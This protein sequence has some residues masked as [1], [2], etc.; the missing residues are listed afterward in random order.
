MPYPEMMLTKNVR[1]MTLVELYSLPLGGHAFA[2]TRPKRN[3][4]DLGVA[5]T[6]PSQRLKSTTGC[7]QLA[8]ATISL[9][10]SLQS[11][12]LQMWMTGGSPSKNDPVAAA[13][14][15]SIS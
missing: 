5:K 8:F 11:R 12:S 3:I 10:A 15:D 13:N 1:L 9:T 4:N 7:R 14:T 2:A 6:C